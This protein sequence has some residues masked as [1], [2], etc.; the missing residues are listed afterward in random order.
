VEH[1]EITNVEECSTWN[2]SVER[3]LANSPNPL[4]LQQDAQCISLH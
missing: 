2:I 1:L 4:R 3:W